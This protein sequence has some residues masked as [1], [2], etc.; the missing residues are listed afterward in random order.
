MKDKL[1]LMEIIVVEGKNDLRAVKNAVDAEIITTSG[2]G[3]NDKNISL[4]K[5]AGEKNGVIVLT[6]S[7]YAGEKIRKKV[8]KIL[9]GN[10]K[11]AFVPKSE[12]TK[13]GDIG[14]ENS[15]K[16]SIILALKK[17]RMRSKNTENTFNMKDMI[18]YSLTGEKNSSNLRDFVG[19]ILGIGYANTKTFLSRLNSFQVT[20]DELENTIKKYYEEQIWL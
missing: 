13:D 11:H 10:C 15:S 19:R 3:F 7:D 16:E 8:D 2:L 6:D 18:Y 5:K 12:S 4:I 9:K 14:V 17:A 1:K 20:R